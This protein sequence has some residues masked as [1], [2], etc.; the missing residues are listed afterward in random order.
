VSEA[1]S[2]PTQAA[3]YPLAL[4]YLPVGLFGMVLGL[5]GLSVAW[6]QAAA[7][8]GAPMWIAAAIGVLAVLAFAAM[9]IGYA[10]K[11]ATAF[12]AVVKEF[13]HPIAGA[14]FGTIF[15][16]LLVLPIVLAPVALRLAQI[17]WIVGAIGMFAFAWFIVARWMSERQ[18]IA[19][20]TP[21]WFIPVVG[22]LDVP[23]ALPSLGLPPMHGVMIAALA[24]GLFFA[25]PLFTLVMSRLLFEEPLPGPLQPALMILVAPF[26]VGTSAYA[27]TFGTFDAFAQGLF[28]LTLFLLAVL[29]HRLRHLAV[30]CAFRV[31]WWA[32]SFPLATSAIAALRFAAAQPSPVSD[33]IA[34]LLLAL[35]S[36]VI[37]GLLARTLLGLAR[38]E[39]RQLSG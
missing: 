32:V 6:R 38:G 29:L 12:D 7:Q 17:L 35:A 4:D 3:R 26:S 15:I 25:V 1:A 31:S 27:V 22:A 39:L 8:F 18:Q 36:V 23:L 19:H 13:R 14:L 9:T 24:I 11:A 34:I 37:T 5:T 2:A 20:A 33:A 30:C 21:A 16:S 10:V 28:M